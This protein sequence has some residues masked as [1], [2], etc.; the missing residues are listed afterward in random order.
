[1]EKEDNTPAEGVGNMVL[2]GVAYYALS[3]S[4]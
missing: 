2:K 4:Q 3:L 1:V